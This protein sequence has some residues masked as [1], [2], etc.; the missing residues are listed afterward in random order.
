ML[1]SLAN[2]PVDS[3]ASV[4]FFF[5]FFFFSGERRTGDVDAFEG[6]FLQSPGRHLAWS[7]TKSDLSTFSWSLGRNPIK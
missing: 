7:A 1:K 5:F 3:E 4:F 6:P 2:P